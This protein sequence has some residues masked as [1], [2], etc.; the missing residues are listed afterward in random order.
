MKRLILVLAMVFIANT[1]CAVTLMWDQHTDT[2]VQG[3]VLQWEETA[4]PPD[5]FSI[6][7]P[8]IETVT[9]AIADNLFKTNVEY[10]IWLHAY[11][12]VG[13]SLPSD[14]LTFVRVVYVPPED[15]LPTETYD[16]PGAVINFINQ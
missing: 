11:N 6:R 5:T 14:V 2:S 13:E 9:Q 4:N 16:V 1:A 3:Y 7:V 10:R 15:N 12:G 8:G